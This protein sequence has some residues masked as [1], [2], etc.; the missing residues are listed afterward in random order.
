MN[1]QPHEIT[2]SVYEALGPL[3]QLAAQAL[4]KT[5]RVKIIEDPVMKGKDL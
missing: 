2:R 4:E 1:D 5:G 3:E